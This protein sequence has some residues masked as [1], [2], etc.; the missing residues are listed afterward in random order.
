MQDGLF[1]LNDCEQDQEN[2]MFKSYEKWY[3]YF[4]KH[5]NDLIE[6]KYNDLGNVN[7]I[8]FKLPDIDKEYHWD[9][10]W[11]EDEIK[12]FIKKHERTK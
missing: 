7:Q 6:I 5:E 4:H 12:E 10:T 8:C 9:T 3:E 1:L 11:L 2:W